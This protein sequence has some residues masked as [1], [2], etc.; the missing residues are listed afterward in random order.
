MKASRIGQS[1]ALLSIGAIALTACG[2]G[3]GE[4]GGGGGTTTLTGAGASSQEAA[5]NSWTSGIEEQDSGVQVRYS[6]DGSGAGREAFLAGGADFAGS[7]AVM[8]DEE[9]ES[10]KE[11]CGPDGAFHIPAYISPIAVGFNLEGVDSL[12]LDAETLAGIF[13]GEI[14]T[15]NDPAI[16]EQNPDVDLPDTNITVVHRSDES[17]TTE[18]FTEY[19]NAA[20]PDTWTDEAAESWPISGQ[21]NA[22]GTSGVVSTASETDG[23]I[24]YADASAI[25]DL[26]TVAVG[27]GDEYVEYSPEAAATAVEASHPIEGRSEAEMA[28]ELDRETDAEGAYP[29]VLVSYHIYCNQYDNADTAEAA[30]TFGKYVVSEDGQNTAAEAAGSAPLSESMRQEAET[31]LDGI[32]S[33]E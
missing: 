24:T 29:I 32:T 17:G 16:A 15:W 31:A 11:Q 19:L 22:Q 4:G 12:N 1:A 33:G 9:Y 8:D 21:E 13:S 20:A 25:G 27:V 14:T 10:S 5:M 23:A 7:D 28:L 3:G 2:G 26:G 6:P 18:N 30:K